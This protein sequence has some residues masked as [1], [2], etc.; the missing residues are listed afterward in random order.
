MRADNPPL[1]IALVLLFC[2]LAPLADGMAKSLGDA[3]PLAQVV[4]V[5]FAAQAALLVPLVLAMGGTLRVPPGLGPALL[6]R[7]LLHI[8]GIG[9]MFLALRALPLADAIAIAYVTPFLTLLYG[10]LV[11]GEEV[12]WRRLAACGVGFAGTLLVLQPSLEEAGAAALLPLGVAAIFAVFTGLTRHCGR[13]MAPLPMQAVSGLAGALILVPLIL[14]AEG[15][16]WAE[17][18]P[19]RPDARAAWLLAALAGLGTLAHLAL[20][21][22][23]RFAPAATLAPMQYMEIPFAVLVGFA[24]FAE[25]PGPSAASGIA[26]TMAAGLYII[27]RERRLAAS[28]A[29]QAAPPARPPGPPAAE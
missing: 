13:S 2:L 12:G 11:M 26:L 19:V 6:A 21:G 28:A 29:R 15:T 20:T 24:L 10:R 1:G 27:L 5:R 9:L 4:A 17:L 3:V 25:I 8:A 7:T 22:A 16:G 18:D 23:L 14:L